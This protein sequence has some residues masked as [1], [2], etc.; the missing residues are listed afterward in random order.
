MKVKQ[1]IKEEAS[2]DSKICIKQERQDLTPEDEE[3][4]NRRRERNK[5]AATKCRNK[6][7]EA[8]AELIKESEVVEALNQ[9]LKQELSRLEAE[10]R[11]LTE[12]LHTHSRS[13][14]CCRPWKRR[15]LDQPEHSP[16]D[17]TR[18]TDQ[19]FR[20]PEI[21]DLSSQ[22]NLEASHEQLGKEEQLYQVYSDLVAHRPGTS[23]AEVVQSV[24]PSYSSLPSYPGYFDTMCLAI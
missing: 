16:E 23:S 11:Q 12:V 18:E 24:S 8:T 3:R 19:L 15:K 21:P 17:S 7:K 9:S 14:S 2:E 22:Q 10:E 20:V 5:L 6:K 1:N 13:A 4:R